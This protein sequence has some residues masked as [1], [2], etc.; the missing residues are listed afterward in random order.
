MNDTGE[1]L[2]QLTADENIIML[3]LVTF[4][5]YGCRICI[6]ETRGKPI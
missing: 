1:G 6:S 2:Q 3:R 4:V 5:Y